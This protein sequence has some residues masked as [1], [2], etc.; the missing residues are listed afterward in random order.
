MQNIHFFYILAYKLNL[1]IL[2]GPG[3]NS[4]NFIILSNNF[5][6]GCDYLLANWNRIMKSY[7]QE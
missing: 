6:G 5:R 3:I 1:N 4:P 7:K 2:I